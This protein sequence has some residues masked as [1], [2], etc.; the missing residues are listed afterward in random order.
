MFACKNGYIAKAAKSIAIIWTIAIRADPRES[1][2]LNLN[3]IIPFVLLY[4]QK[5]QKVFWHLGKLLL[6]K[7]T[8][9][10]ISVL[11]REIKRW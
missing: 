4:A 3:R 10:L 5:T 7:E 2:R 6:S 9:A 8:K 1:S 11:F